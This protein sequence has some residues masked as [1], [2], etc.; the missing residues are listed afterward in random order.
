MVVID[1]SDRM[2]RRVMTFH[3]LKTTFILPLSGGSSTVRATRRNQIMPIFPVFLSFTFTIVDRIEWIER[4]KRYVEIEI[5]KI[6]V[7]RVLC[8]IHYFILSD[9]SITIFQPAKIG[10]SAQPPRLIPPILGRIDA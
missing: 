6:S 8:A 2:D 7:G 9:A 5:I 10:V 1:A 3:P 4:K